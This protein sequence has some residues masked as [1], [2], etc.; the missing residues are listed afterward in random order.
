[1]FGI[2]LYALQ[3]IP[4][5]WL[6]SRRWARSWMSPLPFFSQLVKRTV[7]SDGDGTS[8]SAIDQTFFLYDQGQVVLEFHKQGEETVAATDLAHRYLWN[9][10][11]VDQL[12]ADEQVESLTSAGETLWALTDHLGSVRDVVDNNGTL[13]VH[14]DYLGFGTIDTE[15]HYNASGTPVSSG[16]G[17]VDVAFRYTGRWL[18]DETGLQNNLNRWYDAS[19]GR[20]ISEDPIGFAAGDANLNRYVGNE[21]TGYIDPNGLGK[22]FGGLRTSKFRITTQQGTVY[23]GT[24]HEE[25][26]GALNK[27]CAAGETIDVMIIKAHG[28]D[29][30]P[31]VGEGPWM[32]SRDGFILLAVNNG[33]ITIDNKRGYP[34]CITD[35]LRRVTDCNSTIRLRGCDTAVLAGAIAGLL[36]NGTVVSGSPTPVVDFPFTFWIIGPAFDF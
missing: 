10:A 13:R 35:T 23:I 8:P 16:T 6:K 32:Q 17:Y 18:D 34:V 26:I 30:N 7:D 4:E 2:S 22:I 15:I 9:P 31:I 29:G 27:I 19:A 20:W 28:E 1:M 36:H 14:R 11:A 3:P 5:L 24:E 12:F 21:P 33:R 25:L